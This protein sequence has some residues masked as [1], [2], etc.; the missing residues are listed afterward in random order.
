MKP[1]LR[2]KKRCVTYE[3]RVEGDENTPGNKILRESSS[4]RGE[5]D[6]LRARA[7]DLRSAG[8]EV[9]L[10]DQY[11]ERYGYIIT[12]PPTETEVGAQWML[13][14]V[15]YLEKKNLSRKQIVELKLAGNVAQVLK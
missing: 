13:L 15:V 11:P 1:R 12:E 10:I 5:M 14:T 3:K 8:A 9:K 4:L 2:A 7:K 6:Y